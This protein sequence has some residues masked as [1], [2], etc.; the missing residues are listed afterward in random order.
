RLLS[1]WFFVQAE[2]GIRADL[3]TG[4]QT[5]ALPICSSSK[6]VRFPPA[7]MRNPYNDGVI[8]LWRGRGREVRVNPPWKNRVDL[9]IVLGPE[10][11]IGRASCRER[12]GRSVGVGAV[13]TTA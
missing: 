9:N 7:S 5:C 3:V 12:V 8:A 13:K 2:D 10:D 11:Q 4:V 1:I 6:F